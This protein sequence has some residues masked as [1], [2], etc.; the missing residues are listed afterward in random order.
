MRRK[1][2]SVQSRD[3]ALADAVC[4]SD[5]SLGEDQPIFHM[6]NGASADTKYVILSG[7]S[8]LPRMCL[9]KDSSFMHQM[10]EQMAT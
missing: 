2:S 5:L 1:T 7:S 4:I 6:L 3:V 10:A 8:K 9:T